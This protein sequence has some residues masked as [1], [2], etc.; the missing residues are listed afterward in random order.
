MYVEQSAEWSVEAV[1]AYNVR[2]RRL[3]LGISQADLGEKIAGYTGKPWARQTVSTMEQ[4]RRAFVA[5]EVVALAQILRGRPEDLF[6]PPPQAGWPEVVERAVPSRPAAAIADPPEGARSEDEPAPSRRFDSEQLDTDFLAMNRLALMLGSQHE[7]GLHY[8]TA[9]AD[10]IAET[11]RPHP[12]RDQHGA[13]YNALLRE[14]R[15]G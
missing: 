15:N 9:A 3:Q 7:W 14:W 4:G 5:A 11:G 12:G 1:I 8:L 13:D 2:A 6:A 10:L